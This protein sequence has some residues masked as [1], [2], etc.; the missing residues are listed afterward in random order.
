MSDFDPFS[1]LQKDLDICD[2][3]SALFIC[4][5]IL[6]TDPNNFE[7]IFSKCYSLLCCQKNMELEYYSSTLPEKFAKNHYILK[8]RC[9]GLE[10]QKMYSEILVLLG[11]DSSNPFVYPLIPLEEVNESKLLK[12]IRDNAL[13][14]LSLIE[15][16]PKRKQQTPIQNFDDPFS[17][18]NITNKIIDAFKNKDPQV[19]QQ[20]TLKFD[21]TSSNDG[22]LLTAC[23]VYQYLVGRNE[24][25]EQLMTKATINEPDLEIA[26]LS[27]LYFYI[28][29]EEWDKGFSILKKASRRFPDSESICLFGIS[30]N[31]KCDS[32]QNARQWIHKIRKNS[33]TNPF[34]LHEIGVAFLKEGNIHESEIYFRKI[35]DNKAIKDN[36]IL[37]AAYINYGHCLRKRNEFKKAITS[38]QNSLSYDYKTAEALASIGFTYH[39]MG[40]IDTAILYYNNCLSVDFAHPFATRMLDIALRTSSNPP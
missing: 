34:L 2:W 38:Y 5:Q 26:W 30:L 10:H 21:H 18:N 32:V 23:G 28:E 12:P 14:N 40:D 9:T 31:L 25:G 22:L 29:I 17:P 20:F 16:P 3:K 13:F 15:T 7:A 27:L 4:E 11:G 33:I 36:D 19:I 8:L 24:Y 1:I 35:I 37:S 6:S 39:L